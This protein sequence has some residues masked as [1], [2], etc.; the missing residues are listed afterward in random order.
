MIYL[1]LAHGFEEVEALAPLDLLRRA[2]LPVTTVGIGGDVIVGAHG[3]PVQADI[4][5]TLYRDAKPEMVILP[6]GMPGARHLDESRTVEAALHAAAASNA[7]MAAICA[8]PM[9]LGKRGYLEG[10]TAVCYPGFEEHLKGAKLAPKGVRVITDGKVI[11][12]AGMG[13]AIEFGLS[14]VAALKGPDAA[15]ELCRV[16]LA[17]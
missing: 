3:I 12:A 17:D 8:A 15:E 6:G 10:K 5:E 14:L 11:T 9:V 4:P 2:G 7:Y 16:I 13:A 1:F